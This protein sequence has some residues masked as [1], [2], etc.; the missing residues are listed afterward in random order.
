MQR[1]KKERL[2]ADTEMTGA[3]ILLKALID[4][5]V[6]IIFGYPVAA[7]LPIYAA[8]SMQN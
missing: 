7:V 2:V 5:G 3:E 8:L 1:S 6:E 4:Q